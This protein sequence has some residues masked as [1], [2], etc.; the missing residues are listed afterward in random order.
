MMKASL[1]KFYEY[2]GSDEELM[3]FVRINV[4]WNEESFI[5]MEQLIREVIRDYANDDSYPKRFIIYIMRDIPSIIGMLSHFKVCT[6]DYIQKGYTQESYRNL[7]A[8]RVERLQK[9][10]EDFIMSL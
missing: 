5:K 3:Y 2:L 1:K 7:I 10:I 6:E 8:E 9:V 4:D